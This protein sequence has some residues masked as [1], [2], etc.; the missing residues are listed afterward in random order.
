[1]RK[2]LPI[3]IFGLTLSTLQATE[4]FVSTALG[5]DGNSC[6]TAQTGGANAKLTIDAGIQCLSSGDTL[7][8]EVGTYVEPINTSTITD[9][10][11][12]ITD[13]TDAT[14]IQ[15][16]S[17]DTVTLQPTTEK[18]V[19][20]LANTD[21]YIIFKDLVFDAVNIN[22]PCASGGENRQGVKISSP[23]HHIRFDGVEVKNSCN[24]GF[25]TGNDSHSNEWL[26]CIVHDTNWE[27]SHGIYINDDN[28]VIDG[29]TIYNIQNIGI[30]QFN[31][32]GS[33][34][35]NIMRNNLIYNNGIGPDRGGGI[36]IG[37]GV[38]NLAYNNIVRDHTAVGVTGITIGF[39]SGTKSNNR[40]YNNTVQN[41][42][43]GI[44]VRDSAGTA[45]I[46]KNN[47]SWNNTTDYLD[48]DTDTIAS[49]NLFGSDPLFTDEGADDFTLTADSPARN[50]GADLSAIFTDDFGGTTTR[51]QGTA[52]DIA[53]W[54]FVES[55][56][57]PPRLWE[58]DSNPRYHPRR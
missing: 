54:E 13:F 11:N 4:Y 31:G 46:V 55:T 51:P 20:D 45:P 49:N 27:G 8:I 29:C 14:I 34:D 37:S 25:L 26:N 30:H 44:H 56:P 50:Q 1:M 22:T 10:P 48:Q 40:V 28:N 38:N 24:S 32:P 47:I 33:S 41:N 16:K 12:G 15:A 9:I 36:L 19:L 53:A 57:P 17:G 7:T 35:N 52:F 43:R 3:L 6:A 39:G 2:V 42:F 23:S 58:W 18:K 5:S 21:S